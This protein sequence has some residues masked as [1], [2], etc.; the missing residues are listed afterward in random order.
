VDTPHYVSPRS[1]EIGGRRDRGLKT[2]Y[3]SMPI[4][5][6]L[7]LPLLSQIVTIIL[8]PAAHLPVATVTAAE[9]SRMSRSQVQSTAEVP[10]R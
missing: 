3:G 9:P 4:V 7:E 10:S 6:A 8:S 5:S 2:I 1:L